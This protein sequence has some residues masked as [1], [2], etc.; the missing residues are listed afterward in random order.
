MGPVIGN[1][2]VIPNIIVIK[3]VCIIREVG[4]ITGGMLRDLPFFFWAYFCRGVIDHGQW[5]MFPEAEYCMS[6]A[7]LRK[8][9]DLLAQSPCCR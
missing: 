3:R 6:G 8:S 5:M 9:G 1:G 7:L 4:A 2:V